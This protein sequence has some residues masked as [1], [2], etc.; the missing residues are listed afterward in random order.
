MK[1]PDL[2]DERH[3]A[4]YCP[5]DDKLRL[6]VGRVPRDQYE[7]LRAEGWTSTP[8]QDCD[9]AA[10]W[11]VDRENTALSFAGVIG[12]EDQSPQDRAADRAERFA[13]YRDKRTME[14]GGHADRY[15]AG[16]SA[17]G[18]Q[19]QA[20]ADRAAA[21]H[22][23]IAD[24]AVNAW[25]KADYWT[26][27]TAGVISHALYRSRPD[28]RMGRIKVIESDLR[29]ASKGFEDAAEH[30]RT[31]AAIAADPDG[32]A[33][34]LVRRYYNAADLAPEELENVRDKASND[35]ISVICGH[36][37]V[38]NPLNPEAPAAYPFEHR[39]EANPPTVSDY[40]KQWLAAHAAPE[41]DAWQMTGTARYIR[42]LQHR[43]AYENQM[44]EAQGG[45]EAFTEMEAGGML[46]TYLV[47][48]VYKSPATGRVTSVDLLRKDKPTERE[49]GAKR[50][51]GTDFY[52]CRIDT[53]RL[54]AGTYAAPTDE[55]RAELAAL[56]AAKKE[57]RKGAAK[58]APLVNPTLE[59][60][61]RLQDLLN[62]RHRAAW[63]KVHG[64]PR[65]GSSHQ[66]ERSEVCKVTQVVYS[67]N[68]KGSYSRAETVEYFADGQER[69]NPS[70]RESPVWALR[71]GPAVCKLRVSG[72][73]PRRVVFLTDKPAKALPAAIWSPY[74]DAPTAEQLRPRLAEIQAAV[75]AEYN[76]QDLT[77]EQVDLLN[78]SAAVGWTT[79]ESY[80]RQWTDAGIAEARAAEVI[81]KAI[82]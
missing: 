61:Q 49:W 48:R 38:R 55:S 36:G 25:D 10:V 78:R 65:E 1:N 20:R 80:R 21:R 7:A 46:G 68:S 23:R 16:P 12:D 54:P 39:R 11:T 72:Y 57:Q 60:A 51:P 15:D 52:L 63:V 31:V 66:P 28:V 22:D 44:L 58:A 2:F 35:L 67:A 75:S 18:Y 33:M 19:S 13:G 59:D 30:H 32:A 45:R 8:K 56:D 73:S 77:P 14:A 64:E 53:E 5:E 81:G 62:A 74:P 42:H 76:R 82:V 4:T 6:Y 34:D 17:H 47:V 79:H 29:R 3:E 50:I 70:R 71:H 26:S 9:F 40:A 24:R 41:T 43:I 69:R 37:K 27:R